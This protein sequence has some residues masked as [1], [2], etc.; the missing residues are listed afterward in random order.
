MTGIYGWDKKTAI[1][2]APQFKRPFFLSNIAL[3]LPVFLFD[4][5]IFQLQNEHLILPV[6]EDVLL[7]FS[8]YFPCKENLR[9]L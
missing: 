4:F 8:N 9:F 1:W 5:N 6:C 7:F 3:G 2:K